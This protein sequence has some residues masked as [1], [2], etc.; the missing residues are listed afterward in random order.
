LAAQAFVWARIGE[1]NVFEAGPDALGA[2]GL[3]AHGGVGVEGAHD[4]VEQL[5]FQ[6]G[7]FGELFLGV[8]GGLL[9]EGF[10]FEEFA[11][12]DVVDVDKLILVGGVRAGFLVA[13]LAG[14]GFRASFRAPRPVP[15]DS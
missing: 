14:P 15:R 1:Q 2:K 9:L 10:G 5:G 3:G 11:L 13:D 7:G 8:V 12:D 4:G 6:V